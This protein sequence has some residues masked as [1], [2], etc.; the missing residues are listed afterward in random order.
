MGTDRNL[1]REG[2]RAVARR[3]GVAAGEIAWRWAFGAAAWVLVLLGAHLVMT[4]VPVSQSEFD[5]ARRSGVFR[6]A[7][8]AA[9]FLFDAWPRILR[10]AAVLLPGL[11]ALWIAAASAGRAVTLQALLGIRVRRGFTS[12]LGINFL[13]AAV[14]VAALIGYI[15]A[16][17]LAAQ[18]VPAP[19]AANPSFPVF[20]FLVWLVIATTVALCWAVANWFLSLAPIFILRDGDGTFDAIHSSLLLLRTRP[21]EYMAT[22]TWFGLMRTAA[23]VALLV[24]S[25]IAAAAGNGLGAIVLVALVALAYFAMVDW[26]YICRLAAFLALAAPEQPAAAGA[27]AAP[28]APAEVA[29]DASTGE[30]PAAT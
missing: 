16:I 9:R 29:G 28:M 3:P 24:L 20:A 30:A 5:L 14:T 18:L 13:R 23:L 27:S 10:V 19:Q 17:V 15:G 25:L 26:L 7:D 11:S 1:V 4:S 22:A 2:F 8:V 21:R 12:L 6:A